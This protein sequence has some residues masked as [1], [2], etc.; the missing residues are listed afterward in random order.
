MIYTSILIVIFL[1]IAQFFTSG[2]FFM[3]LALGGVFSLLNLVSTYLQ[4][5]AIGKI[6][7]GGTV[8]WTFGTASRII[9]A[10]AAV[11]I[12]MRFPEYFDL[13]GVIIGLMITYVLILIE[14]IFFLKQMNTS[15]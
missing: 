2:T 14:P 3:G 9:S 11:Y 1:I 4:V 6:L 12:A 15:K 13:V 10:V 7:S 8:K 5:R